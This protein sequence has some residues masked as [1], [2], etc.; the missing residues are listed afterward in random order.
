MKAF[1]NAFGFNR[2]FGCQ[3]TLGPIVRLKEFG[4]PHMRL[5]ININQDHIFSDLRRVNGIDL[6]EETDMFYDYTSL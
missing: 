3:P 1:F 2:T 4:P 5:G 6:H